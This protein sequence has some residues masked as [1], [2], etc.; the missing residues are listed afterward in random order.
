MLSQKGG[1]FLF[2][3][4]SHLCIEK[5]SLTKDVKLSKDKPPLLQIELDHID[6]APRIFYKGEKIDSIINADFS[7]LTNDD[8]K[9]NPTHI[10]IEYTDKESKFGTKAIVHNRQLRKLEDGQLIVGCEPLVK[11]RFK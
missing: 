7:F 4:G 3:E 9:I 8:S 5:P 2:R 1:R 6:S 10:D 11:G